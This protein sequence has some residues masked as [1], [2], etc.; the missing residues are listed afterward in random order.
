MYVDR[1]REGRR[2]TRVKGQDER[3]C[4]GGF[5]IGGDGGRGGDGGGVFPARYCS[6]PSC[7]KKRYQAET[8]K[9]VVI[10]A[11]LPHSPELHYAQRNSVCVM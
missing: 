6:H 3:W 7:T 11:V 8:I 1:E 5:G 9:G 2:A 4:C 10:Q